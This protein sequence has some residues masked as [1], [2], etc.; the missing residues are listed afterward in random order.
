MM[1]KSKIL[2]T[3]MMMALGLFLVACGPSDE[4]LAEAEGAR[5][6]LLQARQAAEDTYLDITDS[7]NKDKL[8]ELSDKTA[9][10]EAIDFTKLN[11]KKI[12]AV[13]PTI[14]ELTDSY[15][16]MGADMTAIL[17]EETDVREE[18][19]KHLERDVYF[20]NKT[21][22]NLSKLALYDVSR[23]ET[24]DNYIGDG[25]YLLNG[26]SLMG[27]TLDIYADSTEWEFLITDDGGTDYVLSC[28][29]LRELDPEGMTIVLE[30]DTKS[31]EGSA[32]PPTPE[33]LEDARTEEITPEDAKAE[34][35][36]SE[37]SK[38]SSEAAS[39]D[40]SKDKSG[41]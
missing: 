18:K 11:D 27:V 8:K 2:T 5:S 20:I 21:G 12:D 14:T 39:E 15:Q 17:K 32:E 4:K 30:Y 36:D 3:F 22:M 7:D 31:Q 24:S 10:I 41:N 1:K 38:D 26:Y 28:S 25:I 9:E 35:E 19:A 34:K 33:E 13:L 16:S 40:A 23:D 29:D 37:A 6:L